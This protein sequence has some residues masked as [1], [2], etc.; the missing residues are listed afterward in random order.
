MR[1]KE[2]AVRVCRVLF[3]RTSLEKERKR[4][5]RRKCQRSKKCNPL[6]LTRYMNQTRS[7]ARRSHHLS[8]LSRCAPPRQNYIHDVPRISILN[9]IIVPRC[10]RIFNR[11]LGICPDSSCHACL[12]T[13]WRP[14][15]STRGDNRI[16][17]LTISIVKMPKDF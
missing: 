11:V 1:F 8:R 9:K 2:R 3:Q 13:F 6:S 4:D 14:A 10:R 17:R 15:H 5:C 16:P 12:G 7:Y